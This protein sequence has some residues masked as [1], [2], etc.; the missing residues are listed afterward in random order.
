[1]LVIAYTRCYVIIGR[2]SLCGGCCRLLRRCWRPIGRPLQ[3]IIT[4]PADTQLHY[5]LPYIRQRSF[6]RRACEDT[7]QDTASDAKALGA[8]A[9]LC[10]FFHSMCTLRCYIEKVRWKAR[11]RL[12][13]AVRGECQL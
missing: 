9:R 8:K 6:I 7:A 5:S 4:S 2:R 1:M 13:E 3:I 11:E 10:L 12:I